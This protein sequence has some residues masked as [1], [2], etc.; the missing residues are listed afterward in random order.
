MLTD[1]ISTILLCPSKESCQNLSDEGFSDV[2]CDGELISP[3]DIKKNSFDRKKC[4]VV[5]VGDVMVDALRMVQSSLVMSEEL[6]K[7]LAGEKYIVLTMHRAENVDYI[8][9]LTLLLEALADSPVQIIFPIHPRTR[10]RISDFN[11]DNYIKRFPFIEVEPLG[12]KEMLGAVRSA[13]MVVTDSGGL[14]KE[15]FMLGVPCVTLRTETEWVE[16]VEAG[17]NKLSP[18]PERGFLNKALNWADNVRSI[19]QPQVYGDG[20]ASKRIADIISVIC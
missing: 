13:S 14:Q 4:M 11:L 1:H 20:Y 6:Q 2:V 12:Y 19:D 7:E 10:G 5:N 18:E 15:A 3:E 8:E 9:R 16:T 17:W